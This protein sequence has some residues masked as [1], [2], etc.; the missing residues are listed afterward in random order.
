MLLAAFGNPIDVGAQCQATDAKT[1]NS[2]LSMDQFDRQNTFFV[3]I[4]DLSR[5]NAMKFDF[6]QPGRRGSARRREDISKGGANRRFNIVSAVHG[7]RSIQMF[8]E[9]AKIV[10]AEEMVRMIV[11]KHRR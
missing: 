8:W 5:P 2:E 1:Q 11:R 3:D 4:K 6:R 10:H 7:H 9:L